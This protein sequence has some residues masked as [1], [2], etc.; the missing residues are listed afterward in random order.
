MTA[1]VAPS[2]GPS[3]D[4]GDVLQAIRAACYPARFEVHWQ[5]QKPPP[6]NKKVVASGKASLDCSSAADVERCV[7]SLHKAL[8]PQLPRR[9]GVLRA[10]SPMPVAA[11]IPRPGCLVAGGPGG[12]LFVPPPQVGP[13]MSPVPPPARAVSPQARGRCSTPTRVHAV[14]PS[15]GPVRGVSPSS[16]PRGQ[17]PP[18]RRDSSSQPELAGRLVTGVPASVAVTN[19]GAWAPA[20]RPGCGAASPRQA[21]VSPVRRVASGATPPQGCQVPAAARVSSPLSPRALLLPAGAL[22]NH[23]LSPARRPVVAEPVTDMSSSPQVANAEVPQTTGGTP[24]SILAMPTGTGW[25]VVPS[26]NVVVGSRGSA[27]P[28]DAVHADG[29]KGGSVGVQTPSAA[30]RINFGV[31]GSSLGASPS[32]ISVQLRPQRPVEF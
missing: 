8:D 6:E 22:N 20:P 17:S 21:A 11:G 3:V 31:G 4:L 5:L 29:G 9:E 15:S 27:E 25:L 24:G 7:A 10:T 2:S 23:P 28:S 12:A 13:V 14:S 16:T 18:R 26:S 30:G 1:D 19:G 32:Q